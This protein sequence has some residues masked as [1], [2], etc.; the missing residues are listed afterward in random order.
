MSSKAKVIGMKGQVIEVECDVDAMPKLHDVFVL[1]EDPNVWLEVNES[2]SENSVYCFCLSSTK[3]IYRGAEV[4]NTGSSL[5]IPVGDEVLGRVID[6]FGEA[7]DGGAPL[8]KKKLRSIMESNEI[9]EEI[10]VPDTILET[11]IK[12]L[13]FFSPLPKGGKVGLFGGAGVGKTVLLTEV[14][15]NVVVLNK[16][17]SVS[18]FAGVGERTREGKELYETLEASEVLDQVSLIYGSMGENPAVRFRTATAGAAIAEYFR[19]EQGKDVLF[20]IDNAFRF[21]Q[22]GYELSTLMNT[23]PSEGGYQSTLSSEMAAL[24]ERL[25]ST[26]KGSITSIEAVYVPSDDITDYGVQSIFNHLD[27]SVVVSRDI[28]QEGR[29]P[30]IDLIASTSSTLNVDVA[31]EE[32]YKTY[33]AATN[34]LKKSASLD[35][36]VSLVGESELSAEDQLTYKRSKI[37]KNFMT[38]YFAV[39]KVQTGKEGVYIPLQTTVSDVKQILDGKFDDHTPEEFL[40][41][42]SLEDIKKK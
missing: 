30:A 42:G 40:Y 35:R 39:A 10:Q 33:I 14:I 16:N 37:L 7:M 5:K 22:A 38:Q 3:K 15:H 12:A 13:D 41:I 2:A 28:Y 23:I 31:G 34:L 17:K 18:V 6:V 26:D 25:F 20:F 11:G 19:D 9:F 32:H 4:V 8:K 24:Q 1:K 27:A 29:L 21:A 36:I